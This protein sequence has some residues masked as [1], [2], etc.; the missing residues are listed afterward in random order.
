MIC[1]CK[2]VQGKCKWKSPTGKTITLE[3]TTVLGLSEV[4]RQTLQ[5]VALEKLKAL[6]LGAD[7]KI[8][9]GKIICTD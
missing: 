5:E 6:S 4:E 1:N 2:C 9:K 3:G 8:P 7:V